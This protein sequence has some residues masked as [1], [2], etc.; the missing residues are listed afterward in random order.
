MAYFIAF[1]LLQTVLFL[2]LGL[3]FLRVLGKA[4]RQSCS[5]GKPCFTLQHVFSQLSRLVGYFFITFAAYV[6]AMGLLQLLAIL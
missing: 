4:K 1:T 3:L 2:E 5:L 6:L